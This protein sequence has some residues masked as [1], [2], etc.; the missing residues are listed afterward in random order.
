MKLLFLYTE[1]GGY[2]VSCLN[3]AAQRNEIL[4][5]RY[6]VNDEAPFNIVLDDSIVDMSSGIELKKLFKIVHDFNPEKII[7]S[8]WSNKKY[9]VLLLLLTL[10]RRGY[11][12]VLCFDTI[13]MST[14]R[15]R[16]GLIFLRPLLSYLFDSAWVSGM[17]QV[18]YANKLGL[19]AVNT[20]LYCCDTV[21][22]SKSRMMYERP[23]NKEKR[24]LL[25]V[26][27]YIE[28]KGISLLF[29]AFSAALL[30]TGADWDLVC[31]GTGEL[32]D[33]RII[34][35]RIHHLGFIQPSEMN[36]YIHSADAFVLPSKFEPWGVVVHEMAVSGLPIITTEN[37]GAA[38][39][40]VQTEING[41]MVKYELDDMRD[42]IV[43]L[44]HLSDDELKLMGEKSRSIGMSYQLTDWVDKLN[45]I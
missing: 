32:F 10:K 5:I 7:V 24:I 41:F 11:R 35:P 28:N 14:F 6:D 15:Q 25:F 44:F 17:P 34:H 40:F 30:D 23:M 13:W 33:Q 8:G 20:G 19:T 31:L 39:A 2:T 26:G 22:F 43:K 42:A 36:S 45:I 3:A 38:S 29:E 9:L 16:I 27:R 37:V 18:T 12:R 21:L 1:L 4:L